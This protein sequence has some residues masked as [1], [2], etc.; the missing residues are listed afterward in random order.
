VADVVVVG[1]ATE[2][3]TGEVQ[4][5]GIGLGSGGRCGLWRRGG[6]RRGLRS[7]S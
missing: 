5:G 7:G 2:D 6:R 3:F 1:L 4:L